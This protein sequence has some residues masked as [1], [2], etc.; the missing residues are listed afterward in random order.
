M[1]EYTFCMPESNREIRCRNNR[2]LN[3]IYYNHHTLEKLKV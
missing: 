2:P 3:I 1:D